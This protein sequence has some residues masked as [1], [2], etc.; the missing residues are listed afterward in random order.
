[1][2]FSRMSMRSSRVVDETK[3][4]L[5][6]ISSRVVDESSRVVAESGVVRGMTADLN[7]ETALG[8]IL[9]SA[10]TVESDEAMLNTKV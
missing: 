7:I 1:M 3:P 4:S 5:W 9:A 8:S 2:G 6:K 10:D